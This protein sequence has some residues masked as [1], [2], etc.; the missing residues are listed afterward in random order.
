[1][2]QLECLEVESYSDDG[3]AAHPPHPWGGSGDAELDAAAELA[4]SMPLKG[5]K[6][7]AL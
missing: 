4:A 2:L 6:Q 5:P 1:M 3:T 7:Q